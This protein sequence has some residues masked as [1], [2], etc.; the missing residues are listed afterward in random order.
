MSVDSWGDLGFRS[1]WNAFHSA[2]NLVSVPGTSEGIEH[3]TRMDGMFYGAT[4]F[5]QDIGG[6][7][8]S[9]VT[10]M[11]HMFFNASSFNQNLSGWCVG[12]IP[13]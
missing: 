11:G 5:N 13:E 3:V 2:S 4:A 6:W 10:E 8:V 9:K 12:L 7:D 1:L